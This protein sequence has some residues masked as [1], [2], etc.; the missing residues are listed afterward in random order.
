VAAVRRCSGAAALG[1]VRRTVSCAR[2][3]STSLRSSAMYAAASTS[4]FMP[5]AISTETVPLTAGSAPISTATPPPLSA[6][7][8][9]SLRDLRYSALR[10]M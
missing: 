8:S 10:N 1:R 6:A 3:P 4:A 7:L 2:R 5:S 9:D